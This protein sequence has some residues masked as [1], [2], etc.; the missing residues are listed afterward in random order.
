M[1]GVDS[2]CGSLVRL[3][4]RAKQWWVTGNDVETAVPDEAS[5]ELQESLELRRDDFDMF[6]LH[7]GLHSNNQTGGDM[8]ASYKQDVYLIRQDGEPIC[9]VRPDDM[10]AQFK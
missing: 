5:R 10:T 9:T 3:Q 6:L 4:S 2:S 1:P 7:S 8:Q